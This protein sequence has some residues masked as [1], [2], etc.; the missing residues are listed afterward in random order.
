MDYKIIVPLVG[1]VRLVQRVFMRTND[2]LLTKKIM[3]DQYNILIK[4]VPKH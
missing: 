3:M 2:Y 4:L 1:H